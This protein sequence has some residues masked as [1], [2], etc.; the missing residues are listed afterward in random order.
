MLV[1]EREKHLLISSKSR[2][3][4]YFKQNFSGKKRLNIIRHAQKIFIKLGLLFA[5]LSFR[6][7]KFHFEK[8][9][10][11]STSLNL[12]VR[13]LDICAPNKSVHELFHMSYHELGYFM[14]GLDFLNVPPKWWQKK[15]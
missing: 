10:T 5:E 3:V 6:E 9:K 7:C 14:L 13:C 1:G 4:R 8:K 11:P 12:H 15:R 2:L